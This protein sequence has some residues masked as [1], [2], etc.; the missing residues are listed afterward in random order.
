MNE[1]TRTLI[2]SGSLA[3]LL[4]LLLAPLGWTGSPG[5][6]GPYGF[7][8]TPSEAEISAIDIAVGPNGEGLPQGNGTVQDGERIYQVKCAACHGPTG[9]EGPFDRLVGGSKPVKTIG[10]YWP[11]ATTIFDYLRRAMPF[12]A[13]GSLSDDEVYA[14]TAWL[15]WKNQIIP[16]NAVMNATT[17]PKVRMPNRNG[18]VPDPRPDVR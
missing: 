3:V 2:V 17:L 10:S 4:S 13:P 12:N 1:R 7:G 9:T 16:A 6:G 8:T 14:V 15:L 5:Y 11:H 18:F